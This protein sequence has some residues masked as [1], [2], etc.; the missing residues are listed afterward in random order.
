MIL[1]INQCGLQATFLKI[2][3]PPPRTKVLE[4]FFTLGI[5]YFTTTQRF[6]RA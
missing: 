1:N 4:V 6:P 5:F 2:L 3:P